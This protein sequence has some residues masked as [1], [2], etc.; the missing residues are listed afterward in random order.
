MVDEKGT[1]FQATFTD[2][3]ANYENP[4]LS[5]DIT[6][7]NKFW[8]AWISA[9]FDWWECQLNFAIWCAIAGCGVS[10]DVERLND[11]S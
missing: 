8:H 6:V 7:A 1:H 11:T 9:L 10:F 2:I 4:P 3:L 5:G